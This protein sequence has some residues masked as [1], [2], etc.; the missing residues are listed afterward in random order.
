MKLTRLFSIVF[1][2]SFLVLIVIDPNYGFAQGS[3]PPNG[4][5]AFASDRDGD[6]EI[7]TIDTRGLNLRQ[8]TDNSSRDVRPQWSPDASRIAFLS[9][10]NTANADQTEVF[11]MNADGSSVTPLIIVATSLLWSPDG[12][13]IAVGSQQG[14]KVVE[15]DQPGVSYDISRSN[16]GFSWSPDGTK[17]AFAEDIGYN[18]EIFYSNYDGTGRIRLTD[19]PAGDFSPSWSPDGTQIAF[20]SDRNQNLLF[21]QRELFILNLNTNDIIQL[22]SDTVASD[23]PIW[24]LDGTKIVYKRDGSDIVI[25]V[26]NSQAEVNLKKGQLAYSPQSWSPLGTHLIFVD[27]FDILSA[28]MRRTGIWIADVQTGERIVL[29]DHPSSNIDPAWAPHPQIAATPTSVGNPELTATPIVTVEPIRLGEIIITESQLETVWDV[30]DVPQNNCSGVATLTQE[31]ALQRAVSRSVSLNDGRVKAACEAFEIGGS[32]GLEF[33]K[34]FASVFGEIGV[35]TWNAVC[36]QIEER[37]EVRE[38]GEILS[39]IS[40]TVSALAGTSVIHRITAYLATTRGFI[41]VKQ[42]SE[43]VFVPFEIPER[44][45]VVAETFPGSCP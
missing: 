31:Y 27:T 21:D 40:T 8:L 23:H 13:R 4:P 26:L 20:R 28:F 33:G 18:A 6:Y 14:V 17:I 34:A 24:S 11:V 32:V 41:E 35:E 45:R 25:E 9:D 22:T 3:V 30:Q 12:K 29:V 42:S 37:F 15:V 7:Y 1:A 5:I 16:L 2:F 39:G 19:H 44:I 10:R 36:Q 43:S 38:S